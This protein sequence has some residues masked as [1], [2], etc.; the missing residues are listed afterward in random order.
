MGR[1]SKNTQ[2]GE[3]NQEQGTLFEKSGNEKENLMEDQKQEQAAQDASE[4]KVLPFEP[5]ERDEIGLVKNIVFTIDEETGLVDWRKMVKK[6]HLVPNAVKFKDGTNLKELN[7]EELDDNQ[8]LILLGGIKDLAQLR[9]YQSVEYK[10]H[11]AS[12]NYVAVSCSIVWSPNFE[13]DYKPVKFEAMADAHFDNTKSFA[14]DFLM[15]TA[16]NRAFTRAV[17]NFLRIN[18]VG[19]DEMGDLKKNNYVNEESASKPITSFEPAAVLA[20][21]MESAKISFEFIKGKLDEEGVDGATSWN[22]I[23]D[24]PKDQVFKL[25][26]RIKKKMKDGPAK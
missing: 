22:S 26:E 4:K 13:T 6:E 23:K 9:G 14:R 21:L 3:V 25:I 1:R 18:I 5:F 24:I 11:N 8:L 10:V 20:K 17:R 12:Q 2:I 7:V 15:A 16:E 19:S